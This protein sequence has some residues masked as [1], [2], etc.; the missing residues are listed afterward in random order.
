MGEFQAL[1]FEVSE[2]IARLT[3]ARPARGNAIDI[4]MRAELRVAVRR[5][6]EDSDV[7]AL[8]IAGEGNNFCTGGDISAMQGA[9]IADAAEGR[10]RLADYIDLV[11]QL[12]FLEK[13]VVA[14]VQGHAA[15][16]GFGLAMAADFVLAAPDACFTASFARVGLVPD[17]GLTW[18]LPRLVGMQKAREL[19]YS[20]RRVGAAE[21]LRIGMVHDI[22]DHESLHRTA[23]DLAAG[24]ATGSP[25]AFGLA[26]QALNRSL[27][28]DLRSQLEYE[29][30]A[31]GICFTTEWHKQAIA[32]FLAKQPSPFRGISAATGERV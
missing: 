27:E 30:S 31:Q 26:K 25:A 17:F 12:I 13:P 1:R 3:L 2:K 24:L 32:R 8:V 29:A 5:V 9:G 14:A 11:Q 23:F 20:A 21:A 28:A 15:G 16:G 6:A 4:A 19:I 10:R 22:V 7:R 18:I